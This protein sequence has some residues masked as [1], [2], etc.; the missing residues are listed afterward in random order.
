MKNRWAN[1]IGAAAVA[2]ALVAWGG[3]AQAALATV[4]RGAPPPVAAR[5]T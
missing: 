1:R 5:V 3:A 2:V 4:V